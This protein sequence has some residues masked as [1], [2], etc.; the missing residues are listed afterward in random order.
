MI[1]FVELDSSGGWVGLFPTRVIQTYPIIERCKIQIKS[2]IFEKLGGHLEN[3]ALCQ[4][5]Q[6]HLA[7]LIKLKNDLCLP[8][9]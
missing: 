5:Q 4:G 2:N 3:A 1:V 6:T 7:M 8:H 9:S